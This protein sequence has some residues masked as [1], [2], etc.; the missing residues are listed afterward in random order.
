L[1]YLVRS[2]ECV[3]HELAR[4][5][6]A[7]YRTLILDIPPNQEELAHINM[8][9]TKAIKEAQNGGILTTISDQAG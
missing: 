8:V 1:P 3:A 9:L 5:I 4:Y 6:A 7:G 2:Y